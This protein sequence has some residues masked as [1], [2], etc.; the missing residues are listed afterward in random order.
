MCP[1]RLAARRGVAAGSE[2]GVATAVVGEAVQGRLLEGSEMPGG[3]W[4]ERNDHQSPWLR[5]SPPPC[6]GGGVALKWHPG[7]VGGST[8]KRRCRPFGNPTVCQ[9]C[10]WPLAGTGSRTGCTRH[11]YSVFCGL[12]FLKAK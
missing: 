9:E 10:G 6:L 12:N 4:S 3:P 8:P 1:G 11:A 5:P 2:V 7:G